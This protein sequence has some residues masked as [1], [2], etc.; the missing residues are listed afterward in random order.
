MSLPTEADFALVKIGD[1]AT[2]TEV[3]TALC[4]IFGASINRT[5]NTADRFRRDCAKPGEV[6]HRRVRAT[7]KQMDIT[8]SGA[9]NIPDI[10]TYNDALGVSKN[11]KIELY[12]QDGSDAGDLLHTISGPFV[13]TSANT[14]VEIDGDGNAEVTL[15]SDGIWTETAAP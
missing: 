2:P 5:A 4:G 14:G 6:P 11:Y 3:F 8:S 7:G 10:A 9:I 12:V 1:G 13:L 15:A